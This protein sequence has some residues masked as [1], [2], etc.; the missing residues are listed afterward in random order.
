M[1]RLAKINRFQALRLRLQARLAPAAWLTA[2]TDRRPWLG[3]HLPDVTTHPITGGWQARGSCSCSKYSVVVH[4]A[5]RSE[6]YVAALA[7]VARHVDL[8]EAG[9]PCDG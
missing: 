3:E 2:E 1:P 6:A 5:G 4:R 8:V 9:K 7:A